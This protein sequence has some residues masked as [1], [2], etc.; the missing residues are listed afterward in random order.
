MNVLELMEQEIGEYETR[1]WTGQIASTEVTMRA[2][3][4]TPADFT[5][6]SRKYPNFMTNPEPAGMAY[7]IAL[8][9][10]KSDGGRMFGSGAEAVIGKMDINKVGDIFSALFGQDFDDDSA[11]LETIE[12]N[13]ETTSSD[14]SASASLAS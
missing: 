8:K 9:A 5:R 7:I 6:V 10:L 1:E 14:S 11:D 13:S 4:L 2:K 3:P 12:G